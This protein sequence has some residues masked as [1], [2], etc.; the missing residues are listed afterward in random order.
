M[1]TNEFKV[2]HRGQSKFWR[3]TTSRRAEAGQGHLS[4]TRLRYRRLSE[5]SWKSVGVSECQSRRLRC[6]GPTVLGI[7]RVKWAPHKR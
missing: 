3:G 2:E 5:V 6:A 7:V 4:R 1:N